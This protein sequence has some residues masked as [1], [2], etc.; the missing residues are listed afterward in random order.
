MRIGIV[1]GVDRAGTVLTRLAAAAGHEL[2]VHDGAM[3]S[4][5]ARALERLVERSDLVVVLTDVNSHGAVRH[6]RQVLRE[7]GRSPLLLRRCGTVRF[8]ALLARL[9][10]PGRRR[11]LASATAA[12]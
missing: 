6:A 11:E 9:P 2:L 3:S 5:G 4:C 7:R 1:G 10:R 12:P 8:A